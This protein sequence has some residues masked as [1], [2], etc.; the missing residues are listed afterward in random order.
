MTKLQSSRTDADWTLGA[1]AV[2]YQQCHACGQRWYFARPMCPHC[3]AD[4]PETK[5]A[6]GRGTVYAV[7]TVLRAPTDSLRAALPYTV[8]LIDCAEGFRMLA[9]ATAGVR[10]G[11]P[12][13]AKFREFDGALA[14]LFTPA[15]AD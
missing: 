5:T 13:V 11:D 12:V 10:I 4:G 1:P 8:A 6:S 2:V 9:Q 3:G 7:T 14:P 15:P